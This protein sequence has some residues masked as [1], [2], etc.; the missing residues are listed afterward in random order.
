M[1]AEDAR[2]AY[3]FMPRMPRVQP[4]ENNGGFQLVAIMFSM[5]F[6]A[7]SR[8]LHVFHAPQGSRSLARAPELDAQSIWRVDVLQ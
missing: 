7:A 6:V 2:K 4:R 5:L 3:A 8:C 1:S